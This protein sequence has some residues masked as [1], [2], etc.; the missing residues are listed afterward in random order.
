MELQENFTDHVVTGRTESGNHV[1]TLKSASALSFPAKIS[2][3]PPSLG[4]SS[5]FQSFY[6][7][8]YLFPFF[9]LFTFGFVMLI[10][11]VSKVLGSYSKNVPKL[12]DTCVFFFP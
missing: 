2:L 5:H 3:F 12:S 11:F 4:I 8:I 10:F 9:L 7:L 6:L 1:F